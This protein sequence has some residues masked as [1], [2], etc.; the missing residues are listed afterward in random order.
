MVIIYYPHSVM[1]TNNMGKPPY[2]NAASS[3]VNN[4]K[5]TSHEI[6]VASI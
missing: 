4:D 5:H 3:Y 1:I 2:D 6:Y